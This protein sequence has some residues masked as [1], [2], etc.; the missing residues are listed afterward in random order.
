MVW[1]LCISTAYVIPAMVTCS[2]VVERTGGGGGGR[3]WLKPCRPWGAW[4]TALLTVATVSRVLL[5]VF[6]YVLVFS[7]SVVCIFWSS[8]T[9]VWKFSIQVCMALVKPV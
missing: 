3:Q 4:E 2:S 7:S 5:W 6:R 9:T 1:T 8:A